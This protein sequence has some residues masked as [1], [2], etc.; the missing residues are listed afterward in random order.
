M[1]YNTI[2]ATKNGCPYIAG[3]QKNPINDGQSTYRDKY[4]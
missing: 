2:S 3:S 1:N 4:L